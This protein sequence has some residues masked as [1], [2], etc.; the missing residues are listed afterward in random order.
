MY[1]KLSIKTFA[2]LWVA[3]SLTNPAWASSPKEA[4]ADTSVS[5]SVTISPSPQYFKPVD[6]SAPRSPSTTTGTRTG[7]C[8]NGEM[9]P[10]LMA[11][12]NFV[13]KTAT[14]TPT[15]TWFLPDDNPVPVDFSLYALQPLGTLALHH[16]ASLTYEPGISQYQ[17]PAAVALDANRAYLWQI[18]VHCNPNRPSQ[19]LVYEAEVERVPDASTL[20]LSQGAVKNARV[21]AAAGYWYDAIA[22]LG[23][24]EAADV[25][26]V[27]AVL[28]NDVA[29]LESA[30]NEVAVE[31]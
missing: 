3:A 21:L 8:F 30:M 9:S 6:P 14:A 27:R 22:A 31:K 1:I 11:P 12:T 18:I 24:H 2:F 7:G 17:L 5:E 4:L 16:S 20:D 19:S 13:G 15:F 29:L 26:Q 23:S 25:A 28:L 10:Y